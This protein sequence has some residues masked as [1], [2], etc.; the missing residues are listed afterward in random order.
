MQVSQLRRDL[1]E[2]RSAACVEVSTIKP[3]NLIQKE[4]G[5]CM[6][7]E[8]GTNGLNPYAS[9]QA[10]SGWKG[11]KLEMASSSSSSSSSGQASLM[12]SG[13]STAGSGLRIKVD[14]SRE[15]RHRTSS[16]SVISP[17]QTILDVSWI[18]EEGEE[19]EDDDVDQRMVQEME[20]LR[21]EER[22][23]LSMMQ[24]VTPR[25]S[26]SRLGL[27]L[28]LIS[29]EDGRMSLQ[30]TS[31][32]N[33]S[34]A[35]FHIKKRHSQELSLRLSIEK[36]HDEAPSSPDKETMA[37][38]SA[39]SMIERPDFE[40]PI[41]FRALRGRISVKG[42]SMDWGVSV[43]A[44]PARLEVLSGYLDE[45][46][47]ELPSL[48]MRPSSVRYPPV[49]QFSLKSV[50]ETMVDM[51]DRMYLRRKKS[52][53]KANRVSMG[54]SLRGRPSFLKPM[55]PQTALPSL[56]EEEEATDIKPISALMKSIGMTMSY[57]LEF[58]SINE[59]KSSLNI[60]SKSWSRLAV[61]AA[62]AIMSDLENTRPELISDFQALLSTFPC[63]RF[64]SEGAYKKVYMVFNGETGGVE[65]ISVMD[66]ST[67]KE[68][69]N[70][71]VVSQ[72]VHASMLLSSLVEKGICPNFVETFGFVRSACVPE[73]N[74][75][76][77]K[78][79]FTEQ[80]SKGAQQVVKKKGGRRKV[81]DYAVIRMEL[82]NHGD[83]EEYIRA[84]PDGLLGPE[85]VLAF[86][87]QMCF[88]MYT[89]REA[90]LMRHYDVKLLN[91]FLRDFP[92]GEEQQGQQ[93]MIRYGFDGALY[94][95][96]MSQAPL[97]VKLADYGTADT[98]ADTL[99][100]K[101]GIEQYTTI[102]NTP[103]EYLVIGG[104]AT[105][106][107]SADTFPL[108]LAVWHLFTGSAPYEEIMQEVRCPEPLYQRLRK[109]WES[110]GAKDNQYVLL[111]KVIQSGE[112]EEVD[113]TV[114]DTFYRLLVMCGLP[115]KQEMHE[116]SPKN[117]VWAAVEESI[118]WEE[119]NKVLQF[120][121][122]PAYHIF[123]DISQNGHP[124]HLHV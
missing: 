101:I 51:K 12:A 70:E 71:A 35:S 124:S 44:D 39:S 69:G 50:E 20:K 24:V 106:A 26:Y 80:V 47:P 94:Q 16:I 72:E 54:V 67:I 110:N 82:C 77:S 116:V 123:R 45:A 78:E 17:L 48:R 31:T 25:Q 103:I 13:P 42:T 111:K 18:D 2:V 55:K 36:N 58:L 15:Y 107:F 73:C 89:A 59:V 109:V 105:Q 86:L 40:T 60:I 91:F 122:S 74:W 30:S 3:F 81:G 115:S 112:E 11:H 88:A 121:F 104:E 6:D 5:T 117:K 41:P 53:A 120:F 92:N 43:G 113:K 79:V 56:G 108:G 23:S 96:C 102:E 19:A 65:A 90:F 118:A 66:I 29:E 4:E 75:S 37:R 21:L 34:P 46:S 93:T 97:C 95:F 100:K 28:D 32:G 7:L 64:L 14:H 87:F 84:Q 33:S 119:D 10:S 1:A 85:V 49:S 52:V 99:G 57:C 62:A 63:G 61:R 98:Q 8:E 68:L 83:V 9:G 114:Y 27:D 22:L 76:S 38:S